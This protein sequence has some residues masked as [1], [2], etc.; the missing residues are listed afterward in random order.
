[1]NADDVN[2]AADFLFGSLVGTTLSGT[3]SDVNT[4]AATYC[5]SGCTF[6][7][8]VVR[9]LESATGPGAPFLEYRIKTASGTMP[10][11]WTRVSAEGYSRGFKKTKSIDVQQTTVNEALDFT[12]FQ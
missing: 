7:V 3:T 9:W 12:V 11:Q 10:Q 2:S 4:F 1:M 6:K 5:A 8:S